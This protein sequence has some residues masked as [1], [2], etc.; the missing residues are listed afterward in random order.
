[1]HKLDHWC[2]CSRR[3]AAGIHALGESVSNQSHGR[4]RCA[5]GST[6]RRVHA[7]TRTDGIN[8]GRDSV[9]FVFSVAQCGQVDILP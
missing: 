5:A 8:T 2:V 4:V 6:Q 3:P 7:Y 9:E 1:M